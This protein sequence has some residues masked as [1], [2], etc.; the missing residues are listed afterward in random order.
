MREIKFRAWDKSKNEMKS[1]ADLTYLDE[2]ISDGFEMK[3]NPIEKEN[4]SLMQYTG[5]TDKSGKEI[6]EGDIVEC[7]DHGS[8]S[9]HLVEFSIDSSCESRF[10]WDSCGWYKCEIEVVGNKFENSELIK[11]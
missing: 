4:I 1:L 2:V 5:L 9:R 11:E 10:G 6:Y 3:V 7:N 8:K